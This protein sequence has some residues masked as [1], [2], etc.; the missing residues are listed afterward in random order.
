MES[1]QEV[2]GV[3]VA[4]DGESR[5][6]ILHVLMEP[7]LV[8]LL[9]CLRGLRGGV[10][11]EVRRN[12]GVVT[13]EIVVVDLRI[14]QPV[15]IPIEGKGDAGITR[16]QAVELGKR[17]VE[18]G[19]ATGVD[20]HNV[21]LLTVESLLEKVVGGGEI[22]DVVRLLAC[23][24]LLAKGSSKHA[25]ARG[26]VVAIDEHHV[27]LREALEE[28]VHGILRLLLQRLVDLEDLRIAGDVVA[29]NGERDDH[30]DVVGAAEL[31]QGLH[32]L[33]V[34]RSE[35]D[36][37]LAGFVLDER[38]ANVGVDGYV[39]RA[40]VGRDAGPPQ[41]V[42][43]HEDAAI[44]LHHAASV[45]IDIVQ[46]KHHAHA[47]GSR[48]HIGTRRLRLLLLL[49][50]EV[51]L[52]LLERNEHRLALLQLVAVALHGGIG[53]DELVDGDVVLAGNAEDGVFLLR[54]VDVA[55]LGGLCQRGKAQHAGKSQRDMSEIMS[56]RHAY[57][58]F[59]A[60]KY[61][62]IM[63]YKLRKPIFLPVCLKKRLSTCYE[64]KKEE[65]LFVFRAL[66]IIFAI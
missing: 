29:T 60:Q 28:G 41:A 3:V 10:I 55:P 52:G 53:L 33:G 37:A 27:V 24:E 6:R 20:H 21:G 54:R 43:S 8:V 17:L 66:F 61:K 2:L 7:L 12:I 35:D 4:G 48:A 26:G 34:E 64:I 65:N 46:G 1:A 39:P 22:G 56:H 50:L 11:E 40:D 51:G 18:L 49:G 45:A 23:I 19:R 59:R 15:R 31:G 42:A 58:V 14:H 47:D 32:L 5:Q 36:V 38:L 9:E 63:N 16:A 30:A 25:L 57:F 13:V 44:V 62:I